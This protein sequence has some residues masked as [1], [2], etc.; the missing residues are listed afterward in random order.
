MKYITLTGRYHR[1]K[2]LVWN[3]SE[4]AFKSNYA[5]SGSI[6]QGKVPGTGCQGTVR[7]QPDVSSHLVRGTVPVQANMSEVCC[8]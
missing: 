2:K 5:E 3:F 8:I 6:Q 7:P 4:T 1:C